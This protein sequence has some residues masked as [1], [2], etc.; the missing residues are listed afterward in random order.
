LA[1]WLQ[2]AKGRRKNRFPTNF[3]AQIAAWAL[4]AAAAFALLYVFVLPHA[5]RAITARLPRKLDHALGQ[6]AM[7]QLPW[8]TLA[9]GVEMAP[10]L[11]RCQ[12]FLDTVGRTRG[13]DFHLHSM[14][15]KK[16]VNALALPSGDILLFPAL[17]ARMETQ[18]ELLGVL[19]HE[20]GHVA[21]RHGT[22]RLVRAS[23]LGLVS[24]FTLGDISG[25]GAVLLDNAGL[26]AQLGY[27]RE[28][29]AE[30]D[31]FALETL[32]AHGLDCKGLENFFRKPIGS[33]IPAWAGFLSTHP[34][35]PER[36]AALAKARAA[37]PGC[38]D[39]PKAWMDSSDWKILKRRTS[40]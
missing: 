17:V 18:G 11:R 10:A 38:S 1:H 35:N 2:S 13:L 6:A 15:D 28:E 3:S 23:L 36:I 8:D 37:I 14:R 9:S 22:R 27:G 19:A 31:R 21:L 24:A 26:L 33:G 25:A 34:S 16:L 5:A 12:A 39:K 32:A 7:R 30:A 40:S 20:A 29:E 4:L